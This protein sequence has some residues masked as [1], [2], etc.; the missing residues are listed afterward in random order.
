MRLNRVFM[1]LP[2]AMGMVWG[3]AACGGDLW[4][5]CDFGD[6][7]AYK[8]IPKQEYAA[9]SLPQG[10]YDGST[11]SKANCSYTPGKDGGVGF[12]KATGADKGTIQFYYLPLKD[13]TEKKCFRVK[14]KARS[15]SNS[16]MTMG[17]SIRDSS[18][19]YSS[20][21]VPLVEAWKEFEIMFAA[22][23]AT[24]KTSFII[25]APSPGTIEIAS[26]ALEEIPL[27]DYVPPTTIAQ[28]K[29][30][31]WW[32]PRHKALVAKAVKAQPDFMI[33]G[34]SITNGWEKEGKEAWDASIAPLNAANFGIGGDGT[35]H[36]LWRVRDS[37]FG[38]DFKP[39]VVAIMIGVN[40]NWFN[41]A[42]DTAAGA[43][44][45]VKDIRSLS[46]GTKILLLGIF[47]ASQAAD[48]WRR[49]FI[50]E[51]NALYAKLADGKNVFFLDFGESF[52]Q[53]DGSISKEIMPDFTHPSAKGYAIYAD[54]L[55]PEVKKLLGK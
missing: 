25:R 9:S 20:A 44:A 45:I 8:E 35:E 31:E 15:P 1:A 26:L 51:I 14:V 47:P 33:L 12:L 36:L 42:E 2:V 5:S 18:F 37:G 3:G 21:T 32:M 24:K 54:K 53:K 16:D 41:N 10:W 55:T 23:P 7:A 22:G 46:P 39:K 13:M 29:R 52:L 34:D 19:N 6:A 27:A 28:S 4:L 17:I 50:K 11:W 40:N 30:V 49:A 48:D 38:K 43:A